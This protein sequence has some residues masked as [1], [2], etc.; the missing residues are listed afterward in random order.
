MNNLNTAALTDEQIR[1]SMTSEQIQLERKLTCEAIDGAIAFGYQNTNPPPS[2][3]HWLAPFWK[4]G[5]QLGAAEATATPAIGQHQREVSG[6][7]LNDLFLK[8]SEWTTELGE[9]ISEKNING[10]VSELRAMLIAAPTAIA[11]DEREA[12]EWDCYSDWAITN[13]GASPWQVWQARA[14]LA[15]APAVSQDDV[16][17][18]EIMQYVMTLLPSVYYMDPPDGG[19]VSVL[20]QLRRMANDA[21]KYRASAAPAGAGNLDDLFKSRLTPY[22]LLVRAL[23]VVAKTTLGDM[24]KFTHINSAALSD[25]EMGRCPLTDYLVVITA[26]YFDSL[27]IAGTLPMLFA[28][29]AAT[30][31]PKS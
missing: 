29:L 6:H 31:E 11:Q 9:A 7:A 19:D 20:E 5:R 18:R 24:A 30:Q 26:G 21:A 17:A 14:A 27:G 10:F 2:D 28:A 23:R 25:V 8:W 22:G 12:S 16:Q 3:D 15:S 4:I 13:P 1:A